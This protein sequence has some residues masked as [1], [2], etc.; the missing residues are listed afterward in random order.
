MST[1]KQSDDH[2]R[3]TQGHADRRHKVIRAA[4]ARQQAIAQPSSGKRGNKAITTTIVPKISF[5]DFKEY[6]RTRERNVGIQTWIPPRA[7]VM[8]AMP[9]VT[10]QN[11]GLRASPKIVLRSVVSLSESKR[12]R[13]GS[14]KN[15]TDSASR[16]PGIAAT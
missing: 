6:P 12:P 14:D 13:S 15:S 4:D 8:A 16:K 1:G 7:K 2:D 10:V 5:A 3:Y 11:A 9:S